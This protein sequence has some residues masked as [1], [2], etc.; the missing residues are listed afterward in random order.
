MTRR[1]RPLA[2]ALAAFA[3]VGVMVLGVVAYFTS[4]AADIPLYSETVA[5]D[6]P[7]S[8][9]EVPPGEQSALVPGSRVLASAPDAA[10][11]VARENAWLASGAQWTTS[12]TGPYADMVRTSLLDIHTL[13]VPNGAVVMGWTPWWRFVWPRDGATIAVALLA[14]GHAE[15]A[16]RLLLF[17]QSVQDPDGRFEARYIPDGS[18]PPDDRAQQLDGTGW[19]LWAA[20]AI[21]RYADADTARSMLSELRPMIDSSTNLILSLTANG[22]LPPASPDYWEVHEDQLTLGVAGPLL[23]GLYGSSAAYTALGEPTLA[24]TSLDGA[25][26]L[27][28]SIDE[29]FGSHGYSRHVDGGA[30]DASIAFLLPPFVPQESF[31][32]RPSAEKDALLAAFDNAA[33]GMRRPAGGLAPGV[34]WRQDGVSWTP[35]TAL[36]GLCDAHLGRTERATATLDWLNTHRTAAGSIPEK[37]LFDGSPAAVAPLTWSD[38]LTLLTVDGLR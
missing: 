23:D 6:G 33:A 11:L 34:D 35:E 9:V 4:R 5:F 25:R 7:D 2:T 18:G 26:A 16:Q 21:A 10:A 19:V 17:L 32:A 29:T 38:A 30:Q 31:E 37:V 13:T 22:A 3:L 14:T 36:F 1:D 8:R 12:S 24:A 15:D 28:A 27:Q 20:G